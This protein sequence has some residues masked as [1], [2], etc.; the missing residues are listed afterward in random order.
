[1]TALYGFALVVGVGMFLFSL[2]ADLFGGADVDGGGDMD[3][4]LHVDADLHLDA[5]ADADLQ[6]DHAADGHQAAGFRILSLRN[7]TYF[8]FAFGVS[9][10]LLTWLW[11]GQD[12][13]LTAVFSLLLGLLGGAISAF[14]FGWMKKTET[15]RMPGDRGW[16]GLTGRVTL[17]LSADGTGKIL[18][19]RGGREHELLARPFDQAPDSP[20]RWSRV[21]VLDMQQ[22]VALVSPGDPALENTEVRGRI[23]PETES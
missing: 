2:A 6:L 5:D 16:I 21:L 19:T 11:G 10:S 13:V 3:V 1:M 8:L 22:G 7:A 12:T 4:D 20:E 23:S 14:S 17:P 18:V 9:G 15:G